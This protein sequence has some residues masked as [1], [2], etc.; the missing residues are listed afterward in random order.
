MYHP[1]W[2]LSASGQLGLLGMQERAG[3]LNGEL[4]VQSNPG[5]GTKVTVSIPT[6]ESIPEASD[7]QRTL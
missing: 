6:Q 1:T 3:L 5:K 4:E 2:N 7:N